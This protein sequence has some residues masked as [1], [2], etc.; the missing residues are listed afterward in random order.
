MKIHQ[1]YFVGNHY[2][3]QMKVE[4]LFLILFQELLTEFSF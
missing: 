3:I 2:K 4:I 1:K